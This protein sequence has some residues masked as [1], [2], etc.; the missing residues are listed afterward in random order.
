MPQGNYRPT[1][2][3]TAVPTSDQISIFD[4]LMAS[5]A[6]TDNALQRVGEGARGPA[7]RPMANADPAYVP[8]AVAD[9]AQNGVA[10]RMAELEAAMRGTDVTMDDVMQFM[11]NFGADDDVHGMTAEEVVDETL[12]AKVQ[13]MMEQDGYA[14]RNY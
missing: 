6:P 9:V 11:S 1:D 14:K 2:N 8:Q 3:R 5:Q 4:A 13:M 10:Q 12:A 7:N